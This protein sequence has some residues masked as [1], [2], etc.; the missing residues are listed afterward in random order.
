M[1]LSEVFDN[2]RDTFHHKVMRSINIA[3]LETDKRDKK[4]FMSRHILS[5]SRHISFNK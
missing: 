5:V 3:I 1:T 4:R 2:F